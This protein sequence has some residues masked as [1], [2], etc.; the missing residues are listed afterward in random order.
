MAR[1][2]YDTEFIEDG[3][4]ID[5]VSIGIVA[6]DDTE[7]YAVSADFDQDRFAESAWLMEHVFPSLPRYHGDGR[8]H[9]ERLPGRVWP[10]L[11]RVSHADLI[12][13]SHPAVKPR[14]QIASEVEGFITSYADPQLWAYYAAYD[15]VTLCQLWGRMIDLPKGVPM[16]T[17]DFK[18]EVERLGNP[19][20]PEQEHGEH[21][22]LEDARWLKS[23]DAWLNAHRQAR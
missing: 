1:I 14:E 15:H 13:R 3:R 23:A 9:G 10:I 6:D 18:Q 21:H 11:G 4:T 22:S 8:L 5:L 2:Y 20:L 12:D 19:P 7:Y 17:N 16:W